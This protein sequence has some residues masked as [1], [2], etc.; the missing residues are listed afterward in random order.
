MHA[1]TAKATSGRG[2]RSLSRLR[3]LCRMARGSFF[4]VPPPLAG[5]GKGEGSVRV[6]ARKG[7]EHALL[8]GPERYN[9]GR[10]QRPD[11]PPPSPLPRGEGGLILLSIGAVASLRDHLAGILQRS[12]KRE[13]HRVRGPVAGLAC[14]SVNAA[15]PCGRGG[16]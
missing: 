3:D 7:N 8:S 15:D 2:T 5:G 9:A 14:R 12:R 6:R 1:S 4:F 16:K 13:R 10:L 11:P